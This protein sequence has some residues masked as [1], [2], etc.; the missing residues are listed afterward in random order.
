M[1][2]PW[3][4]E[5][6]SLKLQLARRRVRS[7]DQLARIP[8]PPGPARFSAFLLWLVGAT[9]VLAGGAC[10]IAVFRIPVTR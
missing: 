6:K 4:A 10:A 8:A 2:G 1:A 3:S 7:V 5:N 9:A